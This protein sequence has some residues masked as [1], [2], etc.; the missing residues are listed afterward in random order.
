MGS[1][2]QTFSLR[3]QGGFMTG[4]IENQTLQKD[5]ATYVRRSGYKSLRLFGRQ[6][7]EVICSV[8]I[9]NYPKKHATKIGE[10]WKDFIVVNLY[11]A[12]DILNFK[13]VNKEQ[14]NVMRV[15]KV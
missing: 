10:G 5:F 2:T 8:L 9:R 12:G 6:G 3:M 14:S 4:Y 15:Y 11:A 7:T 13:F 1:P